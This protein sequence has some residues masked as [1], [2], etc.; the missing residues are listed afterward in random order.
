MMLL[1]LPVRRGT[2]KNAR[3]GGVVIQSDGVKKIVRAS[4]GA[5]FVLFILSWRGK[6]GL[7]A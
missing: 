1:F 7:N 3:S 6:G 2:G 4:H 5:V